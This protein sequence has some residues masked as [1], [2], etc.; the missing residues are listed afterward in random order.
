ML[1][2]I[3]GYGEFHIISIFWA[4]LVLT[5][6]SIGSSIEIEYISILLYIL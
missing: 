5:T 4:Y 1:L 3:K 6:K 2:F